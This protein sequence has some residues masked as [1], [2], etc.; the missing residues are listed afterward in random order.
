M[1][2][3]AAEFILADLEENS[4]L[5]EQDRLVIDSIRRDCDR[6]TKDVQELEQRARIL[7]RVIDARHP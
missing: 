2:V 1:S 4:H 5:S 3:R 7:R 6:L